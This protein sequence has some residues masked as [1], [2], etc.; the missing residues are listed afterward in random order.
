MSILVQRPSRQILVV[1]TLKSI[2]DNDDYN[3]W[4]NI[5]SFCAVRGCHILHRLLFVSANC[6][7]ANKV[8]N[9]NSIVISKG[10]EKRK[11]KKFH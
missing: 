7:L 5:Y 10:V 2:A 4:M 6:F 1:L 3:L 8:K 9:Y 11:L